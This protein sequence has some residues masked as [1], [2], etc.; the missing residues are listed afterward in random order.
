MAFNK[1]FL[2]ATTF[3]AG[4]AMAAPSLAQQQQQQPSN[5]DDDDDAEQVDD[6]VVTG[7]RIRRNEF[8]S[9][10]PVQVI[11]GDQAIMEGMVD[12]AELLQQSTAASGSFQIDNTL[13]GFV[14]EG[15]PGVNTI[16][17]RGLGANRT[18]FLLN[19]RRAGPAGTRGQVQAVDLNVI[20]AALMERTEVLTDSASTIYGSDAIAGVVNYITRT[21]LD[22]LEASAFF[23]YPE[24]GDISFQRYNVGWGTTFDR[25]YFQAGFDYYA[26]SA[27]TRGDREGTN[28]TADYLFNPTTMERVDHLDQ[29]TG[30]PQCYNIFAQAIR[31]N[32][33]FGTMDFIFM[34]PGY[35]YGNATTGNN[36]PIT[37][38]ARQGRP[39]YPATYTYYDGRH[40]LT[41][42]ATVISPVDRYT[43][44]ASGG[45]DI[46]PTTELYGEFLFNRRISEQ[47]GVRQY[48]PT[49]WTGYPGARRPDTNG[50]FAGGT[51]LPIIPLY[52]DQDQTVDYYRGVVG[53]RGDFGSMF[54]GGWQWD[55]YGQY[56]RSD[57][58]YTGSFI[59]NDRTIAVTGMAAGAGPA[60]R[61]YAG[62]DLPNLSGYSCASLTAGVPWT[63]ERVIRGNFNDAERAFLFGSETGTTVYE[64]MYVEGVA[65]GDLFDLPAGTV[66]A[67]LG[68]HVRRES[69][70]DLPGEQA[71]RGNYWGST[72]AGHT[73][74]EDTVRELFGE[75]EIPIIRGFTGIDDLTVNLSGRFSDYDSY[76]SNSTYKV[77]VNWQ[78]TPAWRIRST[79]G[80]GFRAP[81]LYELYLANQTGFLGQTSVDPCINWGDS[82][83]PSIPVNCA[84]G[85]DRNSDGDFLD[86]GDLMPVTSSTYT[87]AG[88]SSATVTSRGG[89]G[90]LE[91][92]TAEALTFGVIWTPS[93]I[94]LSVAVDYFDILIEDAVL[95]LSASVVSQCYAVPVAQFA[96]NPFCTF[97]T[98]S[99]NAATP[100]ILTI[101]NAYRNVNSQTNRGL[102]LNIRYN[103]E[104]G[105]GD[106]TVAGQ[107]TWQ[108]EDIVALLDGSLPQ[109]NN[110][111]TTE[112]D[113]TANL[114]IFFERGDWTAFWGIN[115]F[116][117]ASDTEAFGADVFASTRYANIP[118][119]IA[120]GNCAAPNNYCVYYKQY[121][122]FVAFHNVSLTYRLDDWTFQAGIRNVFDEYNPSASAGQYRVGTTSYGIPGNDGL[123]GRSGWVNI[124]RRF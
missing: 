65:N 24:A 106:L 42:R 97:F 83:H 91:P 61:C 108:F 40:P 56:S 76:G 72:S 73:V 89:L 28:C 59:Y 112:P 37:G 57:G 115:M 82:S 32:A 36:S 124:T 48:F 13:T 6:V 34:R 11:T 47:D 67:A 50:F 3:I 10:A 121:T 85:I 25:G 88:T 51:I 35:N 116:G 109:D 74:G 21:N 2:L 86:P 54:G 68:F 16:S 81:A 38:M 87:A 70:D 52:S 120:S 60:D 94:D 118:A 63:S 102:D 19:G 26:Q 15:G 90:E 98:R 17:L 31:A 110:G 55:L 4:L 43:V 20:P 44:T 78:I 27:L 75:L 101:D 117:K 22:G 92:E 29:V 96:T 7:S 100:Q 99:T 122:E 9:S 39:G 1:K 18:L 23:R 107:A 5:Q 113:F 58:E 62:A 119:G 114:N 14:I 123:I 103:H 49:V 80:T 53:I 46:S 84:T 30:Q 45:F 105:F 64:H 93:F 41:E 104:F 71:R 79:F 77:G 69:I 111:E 8:N 66:G 33:G 12:T 95:G